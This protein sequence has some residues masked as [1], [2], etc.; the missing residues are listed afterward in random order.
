MLAPNFVRV[1]GDRDVTEGKMTR[2]DVRVTGKP[3]PE[4]SWYINGQQIKD[5][6]THK[7][8]VNESGDHGLMI[9]NVSQADAGQVVCVARSKSGETSFQVNITL[10]KIKR[11]SILGFFYYC[12]FHTILLYY[13]HNNWGFLKVFKLGVSE[14]FAGDKS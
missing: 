14:E 4:V 8:L 3:Y 7:I 1:C 12:N 5:D 2:F 10:N 13:T 6:A 11:N 9:T